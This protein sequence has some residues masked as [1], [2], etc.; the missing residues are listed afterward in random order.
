MHLTLCYSVLVCHQN[1]VCKNAVGSVYVG[2]Y[3]WW[4]WLVGMVGGYGWWVWL[5]GMVGGYGW[6]VWLVGMVG[7]YG[8]WVWLS[9]SGLFR[10]LCQ[11][12]RSWESPSVLL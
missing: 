11:L 7:G 2:G 1:D 3:G 9:E 8:W 4:V 12:S 6:W 5:V 10:E